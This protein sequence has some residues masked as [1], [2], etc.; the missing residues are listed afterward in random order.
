MSRANFRSPNLQRVI[1]TTC[2]HPLSIT[3]RPP[4]L[5]GHCLDETEP[6]TSQSFCKPP[7]ARAPSYLA[8][9]RLAEGHSVSLPSVAKV[10]MEERKRS[11]AVDPED[12]Y[13]NKR[14]ATA[15][16]GTQPRMEPEKEKDLEVQPARLGRMSRK[17]PS[18]TWLTALVLSKIR[19]LA[20]NA[21]LQKGDRGSP[22][23]SR[24]VIETLCLSR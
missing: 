8:S 14:Q 1:L 20:S 16:N 21:Q 3:F 11:I 23:S 12:V 17:H 7:C 10:K 18:D 2:L 9:M 5:S 4:S 24:R 22:G 13:P 6:S 19:H 15:V